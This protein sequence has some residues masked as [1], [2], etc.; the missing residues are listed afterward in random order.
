MLDCW[1]LVV[2]TCG[3]T[4]T[5]GLSEPGQG[6]CRGPWR[7]TVPLL[8]CS[9]IYWRSQRPAIS[10]NETFSEEMFGMAT[11]T[12]GRRLCPKC[13]HRCVRR[14]PRELKIELPPDGD[15]F[16]GTTW[17][18]KSNQIYLTTQKKQNK[19]TDENEKIT[20]KCM[21]KNSKTTC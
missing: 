2:G 11:S 12:T 19:Q 20:A 6:L 21:K 3:C 8:L 10:V 7:W 9:W 1:L 17:R 5:G 16:R 18:I 15:K 14:R 4:A 13:K